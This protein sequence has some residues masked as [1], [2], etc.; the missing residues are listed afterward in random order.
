MSFFCSLYLLS[1]ELLLLTGLSARPLPTPITRLSCSVQFGFIE[2][3]AN[4]LLYSLLSQ[5]TT[6]DPCGGQRLLEQCVSLTAGSGGGPAVDSGSTNE[7][8]VIRM[9]YTPPQLAPRQKALIRKTSPV[10][11]SPR[12]TAV[13][14]GWR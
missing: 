10:D 13:T 11:A 5:D 12:V 14:Q 4:F 3:S 1:S 2:K 8:L 7:S 6:Q 9:I